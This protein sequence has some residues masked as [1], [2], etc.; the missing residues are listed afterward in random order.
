MAQRN[1]IPTDQKEYVIGV[2]HR[3]GG[4]ETPS[5]T[6]TPTPQNRRG[7]TA[8]SGRRRTS[9][10]HITADP[11]RWRSCIVL[12]LPTL[13]ITNPEATEAKQD[14]PGQHRDRR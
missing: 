7:Q 5:Q 6:S 8:L 2:G 14:Q 11:R 1:E 10:A 12:F 3:H 13:S 4:T 9:T